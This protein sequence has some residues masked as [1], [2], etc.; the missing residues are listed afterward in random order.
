MW[1]ALFYLY[2]FQCSELSG[3]IWQM[4]ETLDPFWADWMFGEYGRCQFKLTRQP[5]YSRR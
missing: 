1:L 5:K 2:Y 4:F 3:W